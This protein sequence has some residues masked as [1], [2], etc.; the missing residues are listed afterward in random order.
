[1]LAKA[2]AA[3]AVFAAAGFDGLIL[4]NADWL[5]CW[6]QLAAAVAAG[7]LFC[8]LACQQLAL[9]VLHLHLQLQLLLC[10]QDLLL[11]HACW[12]CC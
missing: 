5:L 12:V 6:L 3:A 2:A 10:L 8:W 4:Q 7:A 1:M 11:P 9:I